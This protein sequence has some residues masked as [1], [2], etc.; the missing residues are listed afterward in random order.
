MSGGQLKRVNVGVE[1]LNR[2]ALLFLDEPTSGLDPASELELMKLLQELTYTGCTVVCTTHLMENVY[3]MDS[4]EVIMAHRDKRSGKAFPGKSIFRGR[5]KLAK[6]FFEIQTL[7]QL[8]NRLDDKTPDQ[9]RHTFEHFTG[10]RQ[11]STIGL[12]R[13]PIGAEPLPTV[14]RS[15]RKWAPPILL[16]RQWA[17]LRSDWKNLLLLTAQPLIIA[18]L[19]SL[20]A[21]EDYPTGPKLFLA[22]IAILWFGCSNAAQ[23]LVK[24]REIFR[25]E[26]FVG[27]G[28]HSY[29]LSK[30]VGMAAITCFQCVLIFGL[31]KLLGRGLSGSFVWQSVGLFA[32]A[33]CATAIGLAISA[34]SKTRTQAVTLVPTLSDPPDSLLGFSFSVERLG[35]LARAPHLEPLHAKL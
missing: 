17:V 34:W 10:T 13:K 22:Y 4:I 33:I 21:V 26:Q 35:Q 5:S 2:P 15:R 14:R 18:F 27:L 23:E 30:L 8:Y 7:T 31:L 16:R 1:L 20:V 19:I 3:L 32:T 11:D 12:S 28:T 6:E 9:W 29:L 24:E 25:R